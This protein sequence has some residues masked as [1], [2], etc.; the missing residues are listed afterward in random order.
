MEM[1]K[2]RHKEREYDNHNEYQYQ[3]EPVHF[4][5]THEHDNQT[6]TSSWNARYYTGFSVTL[7]QSCTLG[8]VIAV[9][10]VGSIALVVRRVVIVSRR[11]TG[12]SC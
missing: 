5:V 8:L 10:V 4:H 7:A 1:Y 9:V 11:G 2:T 6:N 12:G 3:N